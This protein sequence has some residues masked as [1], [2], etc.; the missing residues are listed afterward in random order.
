[1]NQSSNF[2]SK[3][4]VS[5]LPFLLQGWNST[6]YKSSEVNDG[7]PVYC[8]DEYT[9]YWAI[10]IIGVKLYRDNGVWVLKRNGDPFPGDIKKYGVSPQGDPFG[11]WSHGMYVKPLN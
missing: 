1:M 11:H 3:I 8:L 6:Y 7:C 9:L 4:K 2:P 10:P 5:G